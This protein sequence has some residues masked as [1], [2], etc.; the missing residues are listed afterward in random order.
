VIYFAAV[1]LKKATT[2]TVRAIRSDCVALQDKPGAVL[3]RSIG[4]L[5]IVVTTIFPARA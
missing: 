5:F 1:E 4:V 3:Q 2:S